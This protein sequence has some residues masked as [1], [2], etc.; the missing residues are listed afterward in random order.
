[1]LDGMRKPA[2]MSRARAEAGRN[3]NT[4]AVV[5]KGFVFLLT[6]FWKKKVSCAKSGSGEKKT[7]R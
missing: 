5:E 2:G 1:M 3:I 7:F 4:A 6:F